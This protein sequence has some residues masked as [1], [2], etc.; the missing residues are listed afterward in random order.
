MPRTISMTSDKINPVV[1]LDRDGTIIEEVGYIGIP[2]KIRI[3][4][5]AVDAIKT[6]R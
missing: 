3:M 1:F 6:L 4:P 2:D 5:K